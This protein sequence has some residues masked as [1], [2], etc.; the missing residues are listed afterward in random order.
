MR[1]WN[2]SSHGFQS[3]TRYPARG[4]GTLGTGEDRAEI[5]KEHVLMFVAFLKPKV[6][7]DSLG[8]L[9]RLGLKPYSL[10]LILGSLVCS[11]L[12][13]CYFQRC[14]RCFSLRMGC[15][16]VGFAA[17]CRVR[18]QAERRSVLCPPRIRS[19]YYY[20]RCD[21]PGIEGRKRQPKDTSMTL[22]DT[23]ARTAIAKVQE[24]PLA[25]LGL[26]DSPLSEVRSCVLPIRCLLSSR[27]IC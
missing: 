5:E 19:F 9:V 16:R 8:G 25:L 11:G 18:L 22:K 17:H 20:L 15:P 24:K 2:V 26:L 13:M 21:E 12:K 1:H 6:Q 14:Q 4:D 7:T 10:A 23:R 3:Y 27:H